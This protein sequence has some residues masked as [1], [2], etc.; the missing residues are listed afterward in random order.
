MKKVTP[1]NIYARHLAPGDIFQHEGVTYEARNWSTSDSPSSVMLP[2]IDTGKEHDMSLPRDLLV[3]L[4]NP[5]PTDP[6][7]RLVEAV[8]NLLGD[9][10]WESEFYNDP[11][12]HPVT[13]T[14]IERLEMALHYYSEAQRNGTPA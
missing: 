10:D 8:E 13:E 4:V 12:Q 2:V 1:T 9:V 14:M 11:P 7:E 3:E 5:L 6:V